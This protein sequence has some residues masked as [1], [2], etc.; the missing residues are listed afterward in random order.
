MNL[1]ALLLLTPLVLQDA[2]VSDVPA[3]PAVLT[4]PATIGASVSVGFG[5]KAEVGRRVNL[6]E[7]LGTVLRVEAAPVTD[8]SEQWLFADPEGIGKKRIEALAEEEP[9]VLFAVDFLFWF[10]YGRRTDLEKH[11]ERFELGL[12]LLDLFECPVVV[13]DI[14]DMS[15]ALKAEQPMLMESQVPDESVVT[16]LNVR[17][18]AWAKAR[19]RAYV[20]PMAEFVARLNRE[21]DLVL[22]GHTWEGSTER[23]MQSDLLHPTLEGTVG[24]ALL[25]FDTL[26]RGHEDVTEDM[27]LWDPEPSVKAL[28]EGGKRDPK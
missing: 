17:L 5:L 8:G 11:R 19:P 27:V 20:M 12:A 13:G 10:A 21:E 22:R 25:A 16:A 15:T 28:L 9:T 26:V 6:A 14:P 3:T 7:V 4:H 18:A 24:I 23:F 1:R 2:P